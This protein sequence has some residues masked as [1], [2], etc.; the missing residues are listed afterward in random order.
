MNRFQLVL[1][2]CIDCSQSAFVLGRLISDIVLRPYEILHTFGQK[3]VGKRY[4]MAIKLDMTKVYNR[5]E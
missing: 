4:L 5:V 2:D 1:N 3:R